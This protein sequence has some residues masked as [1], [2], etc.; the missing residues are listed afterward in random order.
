MITLDSIYRA[1]FALKDIIRRTDLIYAP[2]INPE[3]RIYLKPENLQYTGSFKLRGACYKIACLTE[4]EKKKGVIACSAG[5]HAQGVALGATKNGI[6]SLICL[7]AGAPISKVEATKR[8]GA[9]V[10]LVP[11]VYDDAYQKALELKE[12]KGYTF[13]HPFDDE[14]VIA[15]QGTIGLELLNQLPDVEVVIVPIGG[16]GLISGVAY[17]LKSLK[18]DVKVYGVQ[19]QGAAS[20]LRSIEKAHRECLPSVSTVADGIA[21]KEPGEHTFEICSK[22]LDGIVTVTEDEICAAI[23]ALMEQQKLIAEGAGAVAV[24]AAMFNKVPVAGKKTICVVSGG[25]IDVTILSRV[26][27]RGL[28]MSGRTYTVTLDLH[29]KPGELKGVAEIIANLGGNII[30]VLH[31]R[32]NNTSN[33]TACY[34][35]LVMETRNAEHISLIRSAL[36]EAGY[37]IV[38]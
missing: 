7:P 1:S 8:Y 13:I 22:Y 4:E 12:E 24:A 27:N 31:E 20:M 34:L 35:R 19:A 18:P 9:K 28:D 32:N 36:Q 33:V 15:G 3:S 5:N 6:D 23:L 21:V 30:S 17:A 25:N 11:G 38:D 2:Q 26:I 37:S 16:G 29:D 14:C 10:C